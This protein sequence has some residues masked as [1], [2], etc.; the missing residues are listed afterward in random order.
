MT[1]LIHRRR[2]LL[3]TALLAAAGLGACAGPGENTAGALPTRPPRLGAGL[4]V[5]P[6]PGRDSGPITIVAPPTRRQAPRV[7]PRP[8]LSPAADSVAAHLV[9]APSNQAWF[10]GASRANRLLVDLGRVDMEV[11]KDPR[12]LEAYNEAV[13]ALSPMPLRT[14]LRLRGPWGA[15]DATVAGFDTWNGRIVAT[16]ALSPFL[17]SLAHTEPRKPAG[18]KPAGRKPAPRPFIVIAVRADAASAPA[19]DS[20]VP[21]SLPPALAQ[22]ADSVR[23]SVSRLLT[24]TAMPTIERLAHS[25]QVSSSRVVGCFGPAGRVLVVVGLRAGAGEYVRERIVAVNDSGWVT[26]LRVTDY[27]FTAHDALAAF[28]ADGDGTDDL[29]ARGIGRSAGGVVVLR[30]VDG[31]KL[32]RLASGFV[33]E[34]H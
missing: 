32:E 21:D 34:S 5:T 4:A 6:I 23:D 19:A 12:L 31:R 11:R 1:P 3:P 18:Q 20:C 2:V 13:V 16:L 30:L 10:L 8:R 7:A 15:E 33:W 9:F 29:A 24:E 14:R 22:R 25:A 28:D 17:D 26:P 27:R